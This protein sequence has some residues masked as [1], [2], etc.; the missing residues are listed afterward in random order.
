MKRTAA[1]AACLAA[2]AAFGAGCGSSSKKDSSTG[3]APAS[4]TAGASGGTTTAG[5]PNVSMK[6]IKFNPQDVT[7]KVGQTIT[8]K[9]NDPVAHT[10]TAKSGA[11]FDSGTVN[12]GGTYTFTAKKAGKIDYVCTIHP[13]QTGTITVS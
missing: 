10:V 3:A 11:D 2:T 5:G 1:I 13:N 7:V 8:W 4:T 12:P 9:N 6:D